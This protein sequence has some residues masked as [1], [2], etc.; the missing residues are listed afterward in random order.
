MS[1]SVVKCAGFLVKNRAAPPV[2]LSSARFVV[3]S[4]VRRWFDLAGFQPSRCF[5]K[6]GLHLPKPDIASICQQH[7]AAPASLQFDVSQD[8]TLPTYR[9][10]WGSVSLTESIRHRKGLI[11]GP[12]WGLRASTPAAYDRHGRTH[13]VS[14]HRH[15][16]ARNLPSRHRQKKG[17]LAFVYMARAGVNYQS[18][19][20]FFVG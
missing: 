5:P 6:S 3:E 8:C 18:R 14:V 12:P 11:A 17:K 16:Q 2:L 20:I 10:P 4:P 13:G 9:G 19:A 7:L 15:G 1:G